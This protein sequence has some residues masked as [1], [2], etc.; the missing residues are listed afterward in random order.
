MLLFDN[1][2]NA[3]ILG[4]LMYAAIAGLL[5][6]MV[7][8]YEEW[9]KYPIFGTIVVLVILFAHFF[10]PLT[11]LVGGLIMLPFVYRFGGDSG[12]ESKMS[13]SHRGG[14]IVWFSDKKKV[15]RDI[16]VPNKYL[17]SMA[18]VVT[19]VSSIVYYRLCLLLTEGKKT[20]KGPLISLLV[21]KWSSQK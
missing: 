19:M 5:T 16:K 2:C 3:V 21:V 1:F 14:R 20:I 15:Q 18:V 10:N 6:S 7:R 4:G 8:I 9:H 11:P 13:M 17:F 12:S